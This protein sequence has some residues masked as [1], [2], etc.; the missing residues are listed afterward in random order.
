MS[1]FRGYALCSWCKSL[2]KTTTRH[3][4]G[5]MRVPISCLRAFWNRYT[6]ATKSLST[7]AFVFSRL[8][9]LD[10]ERCR[11]GRVAGWTSSH[12]QKFR[13][14]EGGQAGREAEAA[15]Q[16]FPH[17]PPLLFFEGEAIL[18]AF[19]FCHFTFLT[20]EGRI[21]PLWNGSLLLFLFLAFL[22]SF[23]RFQIVYFFFV[24]S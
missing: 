21:L 13:Y 15:Q 7:Q 3:M 9:V 18:F 14:N 24:F 6:L 22:F 12:V 10:W 19:Y 17:A 2:C 1:K 23:L 8:V 20:S 11:S 16:R 4:K 5:S